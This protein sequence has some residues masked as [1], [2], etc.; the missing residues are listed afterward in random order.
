MVKKN[1]RNADEHVKLHMCSL[2][3]KEMSPEIQKLFSNPK[4]VCTNCGFRVNKAENV[5]APKP[6]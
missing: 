3:G 1:C 6:F 2:K 4:F 5:C